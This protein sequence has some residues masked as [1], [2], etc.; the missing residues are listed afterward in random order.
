MKKRFIFL[1]LLNLAVQGIQ[2]QMSTQWRGLD[3]TGYY[4]VENISD[5]WPE[6]GP[7]LKLHVT[8]LP[9]T[10]SSVVVYDDIM[11]TTGIEKGEELLTAVDLQGNILW[12][13][14]YGDA[15]DG[16]FRPARC[17]PTIEDGFAYMVSGR[18]SLAC[19]NL[20]NGE[21][22]WSIDGYSSFG[23][24]TGNW[25]TAES[26]LIV[27]EKMI[28]TPCG[29]KTTMVALDKRDGS[30]LWQSESIGDQSA[31]VSPVYMELNGTKL[32]V[33]V[34]GN[35]V[36]GVNSEDGDIFWKLNYS[37]ISNPGTGVDIN[38]VSPLIRGK[39]IFIT[40]G[41][42]HVGLMLELA[43]DCRS[44]SVKWISKDM[45]VHH[46][47]VVEVDGYIY[48][49]NFNSV[50]GGNWL[51]LDWNTGQVMFEDDRYN[52]GQVIAL[53]NKLICYEERKGRMLLVK[54]N[55]KAFEVI[56]EFK[57]TQGSGPHWSHPSVY[58][59]KLFFRHGKSLLVYALGD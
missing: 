30:I 14:I 26:P 51:C 24:S 40:S 34:T 23:A 37:S 27:E 58:D 55:P 6:N 10:F 33:T 28:Y 38:P 49:S 48:G 17:T 53:G 52:K 13:T 18:G 4:P 16:T 57:V 25:G 50:F 36:I 45:D 35:Y 5:S 7:K 20:T 47:G 3:R 54:A 59:G 21:L 42:D 11:Y 1:V 15:W 29:D 12:N 8:N 56:S 44:V 39:E 41:Y 43:D 22:V 32:I 2:G 46:G 31:Y 19:V 9:E